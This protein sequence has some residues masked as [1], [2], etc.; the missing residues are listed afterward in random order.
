MVESRPGGANP[1]RCAQ[2]HNFSGREVPTFLL[3]KRFLRVRVSEFVF[4]FILELT[5]YLKHSFY[6]FLLSLHA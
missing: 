5:V 3:F 6:P 1:S 2:A 4:P